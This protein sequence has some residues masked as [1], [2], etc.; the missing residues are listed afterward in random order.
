MSVVK[1]RRGKYSYHDPRDGW[2]YISWGMGAARKI[3]AFNLSASTGEVDTGW[4]LPAGSFIVDAWVK[5]IAAEATGTTKTI[6]V[7]L[8]SSESGGDADGFIDGV[9]V[10]ATGLVKAEFV[11]TVGSNETFYAAT[12]TVGALFRAGYIAGTDVDGNFGLG[13][14]KWH[15]TDSTTARSLTWSAG[16]A[17]TEFKG[18]LFV[19]FIEVGSH[20]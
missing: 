9:S 13:A 2:E 8:L 12:P 16:S 17:Q 19:E 3:Y 14:K 7:G 11:A 5:V 1:S 20:E 10:A 15:D 18:I 6:D 4:N